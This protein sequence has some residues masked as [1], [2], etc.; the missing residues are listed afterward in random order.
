MD[1]AV[2]LR[3]SIRSLNGQGCVQ[4]DSDAIYTFGV[5]SVG[6]DGGGDG[7]ADCWICPPLA[8]LDGGSDDCP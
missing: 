4:R 5:I 7:P 3:G 1:A 2:E 8:W 6:D